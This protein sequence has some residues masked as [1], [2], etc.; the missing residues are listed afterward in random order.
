M[1]RALTLGLGWI[2]DELF[3]DP[4]TRWHPVGLI[5]L[6]ARRLRDLAPA[7]ED[8]RF[9]YGLA[10]AA[11]L[12]TVSGA[13]AAALA[14]GARTV[15]PL[16]ATTAEAAMF[17]STMSLSTLLDRAGEVAFAL[18]QGDLPHARRLLGYHLV[19]RDATELDEAGVAAAAIE[20]V[21]ENLSDGVI[22]PAL[23][24]AL[25][26]APA[27]VAYRAANTL[28]A[29]WGYHDEEFEQL[30]KAAARL[31]DALNLVPARVSALAIVAAAAALRRPDIDA[32]RALEVWRH[33]RGRT[34]SP[35]A[36]HPMAA[37]AGALG[38][39]LEKRGDYLLGATLRP[40]VAADIERANA[41]AGTAARLV[42]AGLLAVLLL[43]EVRR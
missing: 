34:A 3:G 17:S 9:R 12:P 24:H 32:R 35:N 7:E 22:A 10:A 8:A 25:G 38:V 21:A 13:A 16:A 4:P 36:G 5:G 2:A 39:R 14:R 27:A 6:A 19:S 28:D 31:D 37:M 43:A 23:A 11:G 42:A 30:G 26:G 29:L 40:P 33:D 18:E 15:N 41:V 20:S 1:S